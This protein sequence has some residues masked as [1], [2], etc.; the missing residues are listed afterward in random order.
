MA[1]NISYDTV[2]Q[3]LLDISKPF[4]ARFLHRF[5]DLK[6]TELGQLAIIWPEIPPERKHTFLDDLENLAESD[7]LTSFD[8][9]ARALLSDS[10]PMVRTSAIRL[11]WE[12]EDSKLVPVYVD[13]LKEDQD[14]EVRSAAANALG[15]FIYLGELEKISPDLHHQIENTLLAL[16]ASKQEPQVRRRALESLGY[17]GRD[18][19]IPLILNAYHDKDPRW[20]A[21]ALFAMGR[22]CDERWTRQVLAS[23]RSPDDDIRSEAIHASGELELSSAR[24]IIFDLLEDEEDSDLRHEEIWALS[25]IGGEGVRT[26]LEE[27]LAAEEDDLE[28]DFIEDALATLSFTEDMGGFSLMDLDPE[29]DFIPE[30]D[31]DD[32]AES[33]PGM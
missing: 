21:S 27:L 23:L 33:N 19:V 24:R 31:H 5:S 4:P 28:I 3:S 7:T 9:L 22:S 15:N 25:R 30:D 8:D 17:S 2:L 11:L 13:M 20:V 32:K 18:E 1:Q 10:D 26:R 12:S 29:I 6:S 14:V 16:V